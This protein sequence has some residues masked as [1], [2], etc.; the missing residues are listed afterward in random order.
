MAAFRYEALDDTGRVTRGV[1]EAD[2]L[3]QARARLREL[4]LVAV[5]VNAVTQET[6]HD[7]DGRRWRWG[8]GVTSGQLSMLTRQLATLLDAGLTIEQALSAMIEQSESETVRQVLAGVRA[9]LL[10]G[11]TLAQALGH[12]GNVFP[13]IYCALVKAGEASGELGRVL[14]RLA[15][16]TEARQVLRQKVGLAF[17][18]PAIVT[19]VA[20]MVVAGLLVY[21][22]PQ[23]VSVFQHSHQS[24]PLL[25]R[26]LIGSSALLQASWMYLLVGLAASGLGARLLLRREA[27]RYRWHMRLLRLPVIGRMVRGINTARMA[28][29]LAILSGSGVPLLVSLQSAADVVGNLPMRRALEDAAKKVR[30]GAGLSR[31]LAVSGLFPPILVHLIASGEASG[32]LD[33]MLD[34]AAIQQEQEI[35]SYI[36]VLTSLLEPALILVMG[37]VVLTIVLA[38]LLPIIEMNQIVR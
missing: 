18:Y 8:R 12:Y 24:L 4:G 28:S 23:V 13:E 36:S 32:R 7:G 15:D 11:H 2:A 30:E 20:L 25:T 10:A 14:L 35:G 22:V 29:T 27:I 17:V 38:I 21:V 31:A 19:L 26:L 33:A 37:G 6:L 1:I 9:E 3:R 34:R 5:A 16:Y